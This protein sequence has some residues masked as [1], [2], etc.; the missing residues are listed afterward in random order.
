MKFSHWDPGDLREPTSS[1]Q[2]VDFRMRV[3]LDFFVIS[4]SHAFNSER[5]TLLIAST[6]TAFV[7]VS[8]CELDFEI[9]QVCALLQPSDKPVGL[10]AATCPSVGGVIGIGV[11]CDTRCLRLSS[12]T[13]E[14]L[15]DRKPR[16]MTNY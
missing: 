14:Q 16:C 13:A 15:R 6:L 2:L 1:A 11:F 12:P 10:T 4:L 5:D 8:R 9:R 7:E 3:S